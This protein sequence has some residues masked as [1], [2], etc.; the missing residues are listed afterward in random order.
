MVRS[1]ECSLA[2]V[3]PPKPRLHLC[4]T[5]RGDLS[6]SCR[7]EKSGGEGGSEEVGVNGLP[8]MRREKVDVRLAGSSR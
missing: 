6:G 5:G 1:P 4:M 3:T 7:G 2:H 8:K